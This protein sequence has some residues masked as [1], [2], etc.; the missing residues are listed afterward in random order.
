MYFLMSAPTRIKEEIFKSVP[1]FEGKTKFKM[2]DVNAV[3]EMSNS[4]INV[5]SDFIFVHLH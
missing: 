2:T 4:H 5:V 1:F 3:V